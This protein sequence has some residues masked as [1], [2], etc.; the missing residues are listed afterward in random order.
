MPGISRGDHFHR[1]KIERFTVLAGSATISLRKLSTDRVHEFVVN[2]EE[3][4]AVDMPTGG[5]SHKITN[6]GDETLYTSFWTDDL[7]DPERPDTIAEAV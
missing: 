2:G 4:A 7:F 1:R 5:W 6:T 3:P